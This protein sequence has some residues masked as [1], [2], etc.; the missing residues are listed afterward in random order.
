MALAGTTTSLNGGAG[1]VSAREKSYAALLEG[2][3]HSF[4]SSDDETDP[5]LRNVDF[6]IEDGEF[7][8]VVG[9][10]GCGKTTI[11]N[12][13]AGLFRPTS[14]RV[15]VLGT[16]PQAA[17][18]SVGYM[19]A[20]DALLPWRVAWK[21]IAFALEIRGIGD[22]KTKALRALESVGLAKYSEYYPW[23]LSQGMRQ[24][25]ALAR[26]FAL[27][28]A[29]LLMDEPFAALDAQTRLFIETEF[30]EL[31]QRTSK[32]VLF[33]THDLSEAVALADR[34]VL[35][36]QGRVLLDLGVPFGRPRDLVTLSAEP[37]FQEIYQHLWAEL[38]KS[39]G[40]NRT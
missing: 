35:I 1:G 16:S 28:P 3:T 24:R 34:V 36:G 4:T 31:W 12:L 7:V 39:Y 6:K 29:L 27:D 2:V 17:R 37:R 21:N 10:S 38:A 22:R 13:L 15:E 33:V 23:Q 40:T 5:V 18:P 14:G 20:R 25:V 8:S 9:A 19:F 30:L 11:L 26:T 32:S